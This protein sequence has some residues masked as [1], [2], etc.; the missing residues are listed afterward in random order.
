MG[1]VPDLVKKIV[2]RWENQ[3]KNCLHNS[4]KEKKL[5][6]QKVKRKKIVFKIVLEKDIL[7]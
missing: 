4:F 6:A 3:E 7:I 1:E 2:C 5:F